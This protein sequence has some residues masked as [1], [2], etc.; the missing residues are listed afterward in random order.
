M[1]YAQRLDGIEAADGL[2][3]FQKFDYIDAAI[4]ALDAGVLHA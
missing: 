4:T 2:S 1:H 3:K